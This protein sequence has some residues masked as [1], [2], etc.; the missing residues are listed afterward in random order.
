M[1]YANEKWL[2][3][4]KSALKKVE[5]GLQDAA[6]G[7]LVKKGSFLKYTDDDTEKYRINY[8]SHSNQVMIKKS[9]L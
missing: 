1:I 8:Y 5:Q 2:Y 3:D 6:A 9:P 4:N 7:H